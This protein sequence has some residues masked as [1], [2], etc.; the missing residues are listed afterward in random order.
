MKARTGTGFVS[1]SS[2]SSFCVVGFKLNKKLKKLLKDK[3]SLE[4][5]EYEQEYWGCSKCDSEIAYSKPEYCSKC[6]GKMETKIRMVTD[7]L[8]FYDVCET[9][10]LSYHSETDHGEVVGLNAENKTIAQLT[11]VQEK[12]NDILGIKVDCKIYSGEEAC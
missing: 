7:E 5:E 12:I 11:K 8:S 2:T 1:N 3:A 9:L 10:G 4:N 6:G